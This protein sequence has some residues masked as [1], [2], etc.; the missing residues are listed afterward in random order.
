MTTH[1]CYSI[2]TRY[3]ICFAYLSLPCNSQCST[4]SIISFWFQSPLHAFITQE[5]TEPQSHISWWIKLS[6][7]CCHLS[8]SHILTFHFLYT[9]TRMPLP[10]NVLCY[11]RIIVLTFC[12]VLPLCICIFRISI[13]T[14]T[15]LPVLFSPFNTKYTT[16]TAY[17]EPTNLPLW[18]LSHD[19]WYYYCL[20]VSH[21]SPV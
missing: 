19:L 11:P 3:P 13:M 4:V 9:G 14:L 8:L 18:S 6:L 20:T 12:L 5:E 16:C 7:T 1:I 15:N 10:Y 17:N 2:R 21:P